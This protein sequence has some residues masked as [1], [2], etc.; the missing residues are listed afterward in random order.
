MAQGDM[1][2]L[3]RQTTFGEGGAV[4][5]FGEATREY[6][7]AS[8][9]LST[10]GATVAQT[11]SQQLA[12]QWGYQA[13]KTPHGDTLPAITDFDK[14]FVNSYHTQAEATLS[15][16]GKKLLTDA[17]TQLATSIRL[18][19]DLINKTN[20]QV[21]QGL[22]KI[23]EQAPTAVKGSLEAQFA[24]ELM[25]Q[26]QKYKVKMWN[27]AREDQ[28]NT[29]IASMT[30]DTDSI[31][32]L[33]SGGQT[34]AALKRV[35][36]IKARANAAV[37][38]R[39][40]TPEAAHTAIQ[41]A[42]QTALNA[43][44]V[45]GAIE[46]KNNGT[47][48]KY[49][50]DFSKA[51]PEGMTHKEWFSAGEAIN[52]HMGVLQSLDSQDQQFALANAKLSLLTDPSGL[53]ANQLQELKNRVTPTQYV[54][55]QIELAQTKIKAAKLG[56]GAT[57]YANNFTSIDAYNSASPEQRN[58]AF[59]DLVPAYIARESKA[60]KNITQ[61][62]AEVALAIQAPGPIKTYVNKLN[63][64]LG[65]NNPQ[66]IEEAG[67]AYE[68]I[69]NAEKGTN[70]IGVDDK[71]ISKWHAYQTLTSKFPTK[72]EA[73]IAANEVVYGKKSDQ[74][75]AN[76]QAWANYKNDNISKGTNNTDHFLDLAGLDKN[77]LAYPDAYGNQLENTFHTYFNNL[78]GDTETANKQFKQVVAQTYGTTNINGKEE[79]TP[80]PL[81][82]IIG[83]PE[84]ATGVIL[85]DVASSLNKSFAY[86]NQKFKEGKSDWY[87]EV[88]PRLSVKDVMNHPEVQKHIKEFP[89]STQATYKHMFEH[90]NPNIVNVIKH[91]RN[92]HTEQY[93]TFIQA[94][95][96]SVKT[97]N[98]DRPIKG[99]WEVMLKNDT[100]GI[101]SISTLDP[102]NNLVTYQPNI[103][104]IK[105]EYY[106]LHNFGHD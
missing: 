10:I 31:Y 75:P 40:I 56:N 95:P 76:N 67:N 103:N 73:A 23:S 64:K 97:L 8:N 74:I 34:E 36:S 45:H 78:N 41:T 35:G 33:G 72:Q 99:G 19:P 37:A 105:A 38:S 101:Q 22:S 44:S 16:Q 7:A 58:K 98:S 21:T 17:E 14:T 69:I 61:A 43:I 87:F 88:S 80:F 106:Q 49:K 94:N 66:D 12:K 104:K 59:D 81:E 100:Q 5:N 32:E 68:H 25:N 102:F 30:N 62:D 96:Y 18:T 28:K 3:E 9:S 2:V 92:G 85:N 55:F 29:I 63:T 50:A 93:S 70:V 84:D 4:P 54:D 11:A 13:G 77:K 27:E 79:T 52:S 6:A 90:T 53:S 86:T 20:N 42:R 15:L 83:L 82:K 47:L 65:S 26:N 57:A 51:P 91:Y 48:E 60:G 24:S 89:H 39:L 71:A 1:P 46:A